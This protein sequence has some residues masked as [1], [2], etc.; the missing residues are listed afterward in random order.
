MNIDIEKLQYLLDEACGSGEEGGCQLAIY[1]KGRLAADLVSG[2]AAP[3]GAAIAHDTLFP[4]YSVS[5]GLTTT[6]AHILHEE[7][8]L[9]FNANVSDY[10]PEFACSG[11]ENIKVWMIFTHRAGLFAMPQLDNFEKQADWD[12]M[13]KAM[14]EA[15]PETEPGGVCRYHGVTFGW[16]AGEIIARAGGKPFRELFRE[17]VLLP[18]GIEKEFFFG[19]DDESEKRITLPACRDS[20]DVEEWRNIFVCSRAIRQ[21]CIPSANGFGSARAIARVYASLC[22]SG[23]DNIKLLRDET[24]ADAVIPR[25]AADDPLDKGPARW[26]LF[27]MGWALCGPDENRS[28]MF[29][30]GGAM[31]AEGLAIPELDLAIGFTKNKFN[32]THPVHPLRDRISEA[33]NITIRHW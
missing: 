30:H 13:V 2:T 24:I 21:S 10:W 7:G 20:K 32:A 31:G 1:H 19:T 16:L 27:G 14:Q 28:C 11:K 23:V 12:F 22:G 5:K 29:G 18:L 3:S 6:L 4:V 8:K 25:R 17:K 26:A 9:D 15:S 33:L